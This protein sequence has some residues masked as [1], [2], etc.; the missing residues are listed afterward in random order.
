M[1]QVLHKPDLPSGEIDLRELFSAFWEGKWIILILIMSCMGGG[2]IYALKL[3]NEYQANALLAP[4]QNENAP[5]ISGQLGGLAS[6]AGVTLGAGDANKATIAKEV[7]LSRAF[8][9]TFIARHEIAVP[10]MAAESWNSGS[11]AWVYDRTLYSAERNEWLLDENGKSLAPST[12]DLVK[13]FR[14]QLTVSE[15]KGNGMITV[16]L[17]SLSPSAAETW[18]RW[19]L[20]DI[21]EHMRAQDISDAESSVDYLEK[22]LEDTSIAGMQQVFYQLIEQETRTI[23]LANAQREYVFKV[24]DPPLAPQEKAGPKRGL[25]VLLA[26][27]LGLMLATIIIFSR[28]VLRTGRTTSNQQE[29]SGE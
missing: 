16:A 27:M 2:A 28:V 22:K 5:R 7:M 23:M 24:I 12:W 4:A 17:T 9:A 10:L 3:P 14:E 13:A 1:N 25:I 15:N 21:N 26:G 18:L 29:L 20:E 19:L 6:L 8:L 11:E